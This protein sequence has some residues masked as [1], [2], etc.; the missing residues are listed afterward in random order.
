MALGS[1]YNSASSVKVSNRTC[2]GIGALGH[3]LGKNAHGSSV[4]L[5]VFKASETGRRRGSFLRIDLCMRICAR[6]VTVICPVAKATA[7]RYQLFSSNA[8]H[9]T[10]TYEAANKLGFP[11]FVI[12]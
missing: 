6:G 7:F 1:A 5:D 2:L 4:L 8:L 10:Q 12:L 3:W 9:P 11:Y